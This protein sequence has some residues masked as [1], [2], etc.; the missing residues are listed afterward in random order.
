MTDLLTLE[1][2]ARLVNDGDRIAVGGCLFTRAPLALLDAV[3]RQGTQNLE[4]RT[5]GGGLPLE[6]LLD[7]GAVRKAVFCFSSLDVFGLAPRFRRALEAGDL[8]VEE[9]PALA[10]IQALGAAY[11][12][13]P[14]LPFALPTGSDILDRCSFASATNDPLTGQPIGIVQALEVDV[15]LLHAQRADED[16]NV[17]IE[18]ALG[19]DVLMTGAAARVVASVEEVVQPGVLQQDRRGGTVLP[20]AFV[21][22][23]VEAPLGAYPTSCPS[24]YMADYR[25]LRDMAEAERLAVPAP[26]PSRA[27][28]VRAA[29]RVGHG[30]LARTNGRARTDPI[31]GYA[32]W[33]LMAVSL[34]REYDN[35]SVCSAG[36]VSPLA[37]TSYLLAKRT[38][39]PGMTIITTSGGLVDVS[40]RPALLGLGE[41]LDVKSAVLHMSG[42]GSYHLYYEAGA[43]SH[44]V[45]QAAQ[46]DVRG[47]TNNIE[48]RSPSGR[49]IRL[50]GQGGMAD[51][52]NLHQNFV[53]YVTRHSPLA[54]VERV[55]VVSAA[56]GILVDE[57]RRAAG[58]R[59]GRMRVIT[60]L[61]VF[62]LNPITRRLE[63][64][65]LHPGVERSE[66]DRQ[67]GFDVVLASDCRRT[68][69]PSEEELRLLRTEVDPLGVSRIEFLTGAD[70]AAALR[71]IIAAEEHWIA[72]MVEDE[73]LAA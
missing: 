64:V 43:V 12:R 39:A 48:V 68:Q 45:I 15:L 16:G 63:V 66:V 44:E 14:S 13:L 3:I 23:V 41:L 67:T 1:Q 53:L 56:R 58:L 18:G 36:A 5:W 60:N 62:E 27:R 52:A 17:E 69:V 8:E 31:E 42:D 28:I 51:V 19:Q 46:V 20:R 32:P 2:A 7:A 65:A 11:Q 49:R 61:C 72:E 21:D 24:Y 26:S 73:S 6:L 25:A 4:Y 38:H 55:E 30:D 59:P 50:P 37:V 71:S 34:S 29:T 35:D 22:A 70:R 33:E 40:P 10:F 47:A 54:F 57:D 9:L